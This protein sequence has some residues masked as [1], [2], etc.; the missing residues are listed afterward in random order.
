MHARLFLRALA[1]VSCAFLLFNSAA[2]A[3][4]ASQPVY[5]ADPSDRDTNGVQ[6]E[7]YQVMPFVFHTGLT[8]NIDTVSNVGV[9]ANLGQ[10]VIQ[11]VGS[12][13]DSLGQGFWYQLLFRKHTVQ[14]YTPDSLY[15]NYP[16]PFNPVTY[17]PFSVSSAIHGH[18]YV[19]L[20]ITI[21]SILGKPVATLV[22]GAYLYGDY[23]VL[24]NAGDISSG[25]YI[26]SMTIDD[27]G[28]NS[29]YQFSRKMALLR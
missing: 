14:P 21:T 7:P 26:Y 5:P 19:H 23:A 15:Q 16:N 22:D 20:V 2:R 25:V 28:N 27:A 10:G 11:L 18:R 6:V 12:D 17:V 13:D 4:Q 9:T 1:V 29:H 24:F 8:Y 3:Q